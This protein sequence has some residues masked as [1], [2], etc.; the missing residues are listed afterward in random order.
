M[1]RAVPRQRSGTGL[2]QLARS[3][4]RKQDPEDQAEVDR[5]MALFRLTYQHEVEAERHEEYDEESMG[6]SS[7]YHTQ[8]HDVPTGKG[9]MVSLTAADLAFSDIDI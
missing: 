9:A 2:G 6:G 8:P 3:M 4:K 7:V 1:A 5:A